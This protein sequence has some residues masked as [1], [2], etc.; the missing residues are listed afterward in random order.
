MACFSDSPHLQA[1][2]RGMSAHRSA[3]HVLRVFRVAAQIRQ[4]VGDRHRAVLRMPAVVVGDHGHGRVAELGLARQLGLGH[5]GHADHVKA[6]L[7]VH[8]RFGQRRKLRPFHAHVGAAAM[9]RHAGR[10]AGIAQHAAQLPAGR[11]VE[12]HVR[13]HAAA[14]KRGNAPAR[15]VEKLVGNQKFQRPQIFLQRPDRAHRNHALDPEPSSWRR[16]WRDS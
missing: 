10:V 12:S 9:H 1:R 13:H 3:N 8:V 4:N 16:C 11:L 15:A 7:P 14:E 6:Q 2:S 5:V